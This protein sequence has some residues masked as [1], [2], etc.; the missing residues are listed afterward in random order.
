VIT[1]EREY[2]RSHLRRT[3]RE[4]AQQPTNG[5]SGDERKEECDSHRY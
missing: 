4:M 2:M 1:G 5:P 3:G